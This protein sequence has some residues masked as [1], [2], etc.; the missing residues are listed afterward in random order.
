MGEIHANSEITTTANSSSN[1]NGG[2]FNPDLT[3]LGRGLNMGISKLKANSQTW[4]GVVYTTAMSASS[5][6]GEDN[7]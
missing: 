3:I 5:F 4:K 7:R 6:P 1:V 2:C